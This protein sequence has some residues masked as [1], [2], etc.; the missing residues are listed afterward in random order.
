MAVLGWHEWIG[1]IRMRT[2]RLCGSPTAQR[3]PV[4][5]GGSGGTVCVLVADCQRPHSRARLKPET[6]TVTFEEFGPTHDFFD[7]KRLSVESNGE[8]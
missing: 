1:C 4:W 7:Y 6:I 2:H 5:D 8:E 3:Y